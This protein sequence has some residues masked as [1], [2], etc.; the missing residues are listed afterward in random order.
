MH[1]S[2]ATI[3]STTP[4]RCAPDE[5]SI[6]LDDM[7]PISDSDADSSEDSSSE[8]ASDD[9]PRCYA[10]EYAF[11]TLEAAHIA[12]CES[13]A[14]TAENSAGNTSRFERFADKANNVIAAPFAYC[15]AFLMAILGF[16][17]GAALDVYSAVVRNL[18]K[19]RNDEPEEKP[20]KKY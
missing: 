19:N 17:S 20:R 8:E 2:R 5:E 15:P 10:I 6:E 4:I 16:L 1:R 9:A 3:F 18:R 11:M 13:F 12:V 7:S 14:E